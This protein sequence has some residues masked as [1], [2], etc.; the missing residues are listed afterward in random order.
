MSPRRNKNRQEQIR[1]R[2]YLAAKSEAKAERSR[3]AALSNNHWEIFFMGFE[4]RR[5]FGVLYFSSEGNPASWS[6]PSS[7]LPDES[8]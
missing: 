8:N 5:H 3:V 1:E 2:L 4:G 6:H 7:A